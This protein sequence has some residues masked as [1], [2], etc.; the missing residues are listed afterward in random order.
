MAR[1]R[2]GFIAAVALG[3]AGR[4]QTFAVQQID[5]DTWAESGGT[6]GMF[7]RLHAKGLL[8]IVPVPEDGSQILPKVN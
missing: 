3:A 2:K 7:G 8:Q 1:Q 4:G 5:A 6:G